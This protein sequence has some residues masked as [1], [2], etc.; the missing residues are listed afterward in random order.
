MGLFHSK[1]TREIESKLAAL[2][3]AQAIIEFDLSGNILFAN[4]NFLKT[5]GYP[6][7]EIAGRSHR[8]FVDPQEA[9]SPAYRQ[10]WDRLRAGE[11]VAGQFRRIGKAGNDV[12]IEASYNPMLGSDGKPYKVVKFATDIT[13]RKQAE[14]ERAGKIAAIDRVQAVIEFALDG[15]IL[16]ANENFLKTMGY[17]LAEVKGRHHSIFVEPSTRESPAYRSLWERLRSGEY[18]ADQ[19]KRVGRNGQEIWIQGSYNP[20][21]DANGRPATVVKFATDIT[22]QVMLLEKLRGL[23]DKNFAEIDG[24]VSK[25]AVDAQSASGVANDT[26]GRVQAVAAATE[27]LATSVA[28]IS[29][30]M[31]QSEAATDVA[32]NQAIAVSSHTEKLTAAATAMGGIVGLINTIA[33]QINLLA[34]NA[35]IESARAGEAGRGFAVVANEV[36]NLA[37]QAAKATEQIDAEINGIQFISSEVVKALAAIRSSVESIRTN[38]VSTAASVEEQSV[39]TRDISSNMQS[40]SVAVQEI[41]HAVISMSASFGQ[42]SQAVA[43]TREAARVL[44]R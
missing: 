3:R 6:L 40:T 31:T 13:A 5:I 7:S 26:A 38:V 8:M 29:H 2:D 30:S 24:A 23:I 20:I 28:E 14:A 15:T 41:S 36:K 18:V 32:V 21:L 43:S 39:V 16:D 10:F 37:N 4:A 27:E 12:W 19:F 22:Q 9:D 11:F 1:R 25:S 34:L 42:V 33:G 44:A 35:T 17:T